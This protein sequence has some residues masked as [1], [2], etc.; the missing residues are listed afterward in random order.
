MVV[1]LVLAFNILALIEQYKLLLPNGRSDGGGRFI[2]YEALR[3]N[4]CSW[5]RPDDGGRSSV[6]NQLNAIIQAGLEPWEV[7]EEAVEVGVT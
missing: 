7:G 5:A 2:G 1:H 3:C 4:P 6:I